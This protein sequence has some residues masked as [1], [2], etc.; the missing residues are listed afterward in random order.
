MKLLPKWLLG[1]IVR[2]ATLPKD[3]PEPVQPDVPD[4][5]RIKAD[6]EYR[7]DLAGQST[8]AYLTID[9]ARLRLEELQRRANLRTRTYDDPDHQR[10]A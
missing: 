2:R 6:T 5:E 9:T 7:H 4:Y 1:M 10:P 8:A 3:L